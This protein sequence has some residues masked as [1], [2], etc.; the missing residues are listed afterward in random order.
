M[1]EMCRAAGD[2]VEQKDA[3]TVLRDVRPASLGGVFAAQVVEHLFPGELLELLR[4]ARRKLAQGGILLLETLNP[5]SLGVLA[6]S[7]Y[8][9]I[10]HKQP[11]HPDYL[12]MLVELAGFEQVQRHDLHPFDEEERIPPLP[13]SDRL[14]LPPVARQALQ[15]RLDRID[16]LLHGAQDYYVVARQPAPVVDDAP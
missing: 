1:I 13:E 11:I 15:D 10:D 2:Y 7:Y 6:K 12:K 5:S 8:R 4:L 16:A 14:G 9:D 3:L